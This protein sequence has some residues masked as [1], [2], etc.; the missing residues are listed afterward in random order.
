M[1][2]FSE[3]QFLIS[4]GIVFIAFDFL[5][6]D[7]RARLDEVISTL[8]LTNLQ[9]VF[10]RALGISLL[11]YLVIAAFICSYYLL[12]A[13]C[14]FAL[15]STG[16]RR[17]ELV[18][19]IATLVLDVFPYVLLWTTTVILVTV[20]VRYR[21]IATTISIALMLLVFWLQ[22]N[23]PGFSQVFW[24]VSVLNSQLP[25]EIAPILPSPLL[26]VQRLLLVLLACATL[27]AIANRYPRLDQRT[28]AGY[29]TRVFAMLAICFGGFGSINALHGNLNDERRNF[30]TA[31]K[32][33]S[34][35]PALDLI[36][37]NGTIDIYPA[38][39][40]EVDMDLKMRVNES[41]DPLVFSF[42][43]G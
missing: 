12:G 33:H 17:P 16:F 35:S 28:S 5:S 36:E 22:N 1:K 32:A 27:Y 30:Y 4:F 9:I 25:S 10:G 38:T 31:H 13:I 8:P 3:F 20:L 37:M 6:R 14:E 18:S 11:F 40:I 41:D 29:L 39:S 2:A 7:K 15:P 42:N 21:V 34:D 19:T 24:G 26:V 43:P 23:V